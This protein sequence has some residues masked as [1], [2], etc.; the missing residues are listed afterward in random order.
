MEHNE[1][2]CIL[3]PV[4]RQVSKK[5][6]LI[7][8]GGFGGVY[9]ALQF[10]KLLRRRPD[11]EVTLVSRDN[12]FL[13]TPMLHEIAASDLELNAIVNPLRKMLHRVGTFIGRVER[14][15]LAHQRVSV[16][17]GFD[18]HSHDLHYDHLI[19]ALGCGTNFFN[20]PGIEGSAL[21]FKT[22]SDAAELRSRLISSIEEASSECALGERLPLLTFVVAGG[23]FAGVETLGA[24]NDFVRDA[25]RFYPNLDHDHVRMVL[26]TPDEL[27]L[28]ELGAK[29]GAYAQHKLLSRGIEIITRA[30]VKAV[31]NAG[32]ELTTG[33]I[34]PS[35][36]LVWTAG[37][38]AHPMLAA[39][40][41]PNE[42]GRIK[43][44]EFLQVPG[45]TGLWAVGDCALIPDT[46]TGGFQPPT[47]QHAIHEGRAVAR[48]VIA[49]IEGRRKEP[50]RFSALGRLAA[51][52]RRTGVANIFGINFA[53]FFAWWLWR[54][55]YLSKL[56]GFEKKLR[57][58]LDWTLDLCFSKDFACINGGAKN[59]IA[60]PVA[61]ASR[62]AAG[63]AI[64]DNS[65]TRI[66]AVA[67]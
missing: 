22:L 66:I 30:R 37:T 47:A 19:L 7:L 42:R 24:I 26:V 27:I 59:G 15:D 38:V 41:L 1:A 52:G 16:A 10:E 8:G 40:P 20:L 13:F 36:T 34:I 57:V 61:V 35:N 65:T 12:F 49:D 62:S 51:I 25:I 11:L 56:P 3:A 33:A 45:F 48:N 21:P 14:I 63:E 23:G 32:I 43:V 53:G 18:D 64:S 50:F 54:T 29:L 2:Q 9:A 28:P 39:L 44:D 17:H 5:Q 60:R 55:I 67:S 46:L 6:V 31:T 4:K 58:A